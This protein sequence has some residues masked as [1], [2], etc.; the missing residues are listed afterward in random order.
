MVRN[1]IAAGLFIA[2]IISVAGA[3]IVM[4]T[5][6]HTD[7]FKIMG[8]TIP[9]SDRT[10]TTWIGTAAARLDESA[11][12]SIIMDL[13]TNTVRILHHQSRTYAEMQIPDMDAMV[14]D[15]MKQSG[16]APKSRRRRNRC[17]RG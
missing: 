12:T 1:R 5:K 7:S 6:R 11:D 14:G 8:Q 10:T 3:D 13:T 9:A 4:T 2:T 15:A 16:P 17:C